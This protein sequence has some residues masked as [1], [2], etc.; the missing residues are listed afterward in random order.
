MGTTFASAVESL[1]RR[2]IFADEEQATRELVRDYIL[3]QIAALQRELARFERR[4]GMSASTFGQYLHERSMLLE[5]GQL[6]AEQRRALGQAIMQEE[7]DW[8]DWK[9][10]QEMLESWLGLRQEIAAG[11]PCRRS[12]YQGE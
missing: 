9:P 5:A 10:T 1:I 12:L 6:T 3:R 2:R 8:L 7:D 11:P 4:Y